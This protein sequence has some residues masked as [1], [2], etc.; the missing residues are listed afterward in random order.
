MTEYETKVR[1]IVQQA[2]LENACVY[3]VTQV[4]S[5]KEKP[6]SWRNQH[7][8]V[9]ASGELIDIRDVLMVRFL[10]DKQ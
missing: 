5:G 6:A 8:F 7:V 2:M 4:A 3:V 9:T 1:A 10:G